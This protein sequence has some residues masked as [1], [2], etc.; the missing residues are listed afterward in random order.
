ML[1]IKWT[2][3]IARFSTIYYLC[4]MAPLSATPARV[5]CYLCRESMLSLQGESAIAAGRVVIG[6]YEE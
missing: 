5:V 2:A 6:A 1:R 3:A 4:S